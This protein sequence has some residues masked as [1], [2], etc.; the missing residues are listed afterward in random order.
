ML[1]SD[2]IH[3]GVSYVSGMAGVFMAEAYTIADTSS[4]AGSLTELYLE[5]GEL[6]K[7]LV[8]ATV[9][10]VT[11]VLLETRRVDRDNN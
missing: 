9:A 5:N 6:S 11:Y 2:S 4:D 3:I 7:I 8:A 10:L 1:T